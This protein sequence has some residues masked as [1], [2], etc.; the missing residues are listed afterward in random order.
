MVM[1][2][3]I[4]EPGVGVEARRR[5]TQNRLQHSESEAKQRLLKT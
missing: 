1:V 4:P 2:P 3:V 5:G